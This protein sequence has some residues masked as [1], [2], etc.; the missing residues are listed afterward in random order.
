MAC[1]PKRVTN[2]LENDTTSFAKLTSALTWKTAKG[3]ELLRLEEGSTTA[4]VLIG[5]SSESAL[6]ALAQAALDAADHIRDCRAG[7]AKQAA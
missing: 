3:R 7:D 6:P 5:R 2:Q 4:E 1:R